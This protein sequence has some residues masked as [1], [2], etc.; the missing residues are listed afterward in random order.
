M[1]GSS[2]TQL[3]L[4]TVQTCILA[5]TE[6]ADVIFPFVINTCPI[7]LALLIQ[8]TVDPNKFRLHN[9]TLNQ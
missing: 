8:L 6:K 9:R 4:S 7:N 3:A 1:F 2:S 5:G